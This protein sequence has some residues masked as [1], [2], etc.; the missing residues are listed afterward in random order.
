MRYESRFVSW[1]KRIFAMSEHLTTYADSG[2]L[3][4]SR[5]YRR[6]KKT[7]SPLL[8]PKPSEPAARRKAPRHQTKY[9]AIP[10]RGDTSACPL[11]PPP[12][13]ISSP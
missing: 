3:S 1:K 10:C 4:G 8:R 5:Q 11:S 6:L 7:I 13:Q 2:Y 12:A 9:T